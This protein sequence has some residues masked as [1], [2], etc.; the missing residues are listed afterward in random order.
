MLWA[1]ALA[2]LGLWAIIALLPWRP[3]GTA[4]YL[5]ASGSSDTDLSDV[6]VLIPTRNEAD[7][8]GSTLTALKEQGP[9]LQMVLV[10]DQSEDATADIVKSIQIK[11][12]QIIN[13]AALAAGW[14]GKLWA[15]EQ[16]RRHASTPYLLLLDADI[17][18]APGTVASLRR[19]LLT[20]GLD[21]LSLMAALRMQ[22]AWEKLLI[23][24]F[25]Y[26]FKL[27]YPFRLSNSGSRWVAA[28]AG[29][30]ILLKAEL[31]D[32]IGGFG[33]LRGELIDDCA[34]AG[35]ARCA[36]AKTWI[37][38]THSARSG[39]AY[40]L[41]DIWNMVAR[42]AFIQ[43]RFSSALLGLCTA[44]MAVA[45]LVPFLALFSGSPPAQAMALGACLLMTLT[46]WPTIRFYGLSAGWT[47]ALPVAGV[48]FLGMTW[49]SALRYWRGERSRWK[50]RRYRTAGE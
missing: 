32:R 43:L 4:E 17:Q 39:R 30:C 13:G 45:Y 50:G 2:S 42:T 38:L 1:F 34:L 40:R 12:L 26:F 11:E 3:W 5:D 21:F 44:L 15:L 8:I 49:T 16:A 28:A 14:T 27:L 18:L 47:L 9:G 29:G 22:S 7:I 36:G 6:T 37:G 20:E 31:L 10:D 24:A 41:A 46:Y 25:V 23:L 35:R 19:K 48:L 33:A